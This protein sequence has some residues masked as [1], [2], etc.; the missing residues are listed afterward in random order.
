VDASGAIRKE[1]ILKR[2]VLL[3]FLLIISVSLFAE[4]AYLDLKAE[5]PKNNNEEDVRVFLEKVFSGSYYTQD[6][7]QYMQQES[8]TEYILTFVY[9]FRK[10]II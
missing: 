5:F 8:K 3:I 9:V 2:I 7:F 6:I 1:E 4:N 10:T